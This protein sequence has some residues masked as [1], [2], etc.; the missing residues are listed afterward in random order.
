[1]YTTLVWT[2]DFEFCITVESL[3]RPAVVSWQCFCQLIEICA[4]L[5]IVHFKQVI[6][7]SCWHKILFQDVYLH[8]PPTDLLVCEPWVRFGAPNSHLNQI[9][10]ELISL[11][12]SHPRSLYQSWDLSIFLQTFSRF[13]DVHNLGN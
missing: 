10:Q 4:Y 8:F 3:P 6:G 7:W 12:L 5:Q 13:L 9:L 11:S 2:L 1:M